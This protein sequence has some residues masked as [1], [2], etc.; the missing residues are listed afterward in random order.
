MRKYKPS[1]GGEGDW[2]MAKY[3]YQCRRF[4]RRPDQYCKIIPATMFIEKDDPKYPTEWIIQDDGTPEGIPT[5]TAFDD[6]NFKRV[7]KPRIKTR[8]GQPTLF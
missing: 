3:C 5:C 1:S 8:K 6:V 7:I 2:F 4:E